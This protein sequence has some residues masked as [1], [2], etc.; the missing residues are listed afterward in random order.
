MRA[1]GQY[2][3]AEPCAAGR[4]IYELLCSGK[5]LEEKMP[6]GTPPEHFS[7][8]REDTDSVEWLDG[9]CRKCFPDGEIQEQNRS[10]TALLYP[11]RH[12]LAHL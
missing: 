1:L 8:W 10:L 2:G 6:D 9:W 11:E 12:D 7:R 5:S 4:E 3:E